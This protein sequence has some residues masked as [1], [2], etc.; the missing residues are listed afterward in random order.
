MTGVHRT[1]LKVCLWVHT[2]A[3]PLLDIH[4]NP[5][6]IVIVKMGSRHL[7]PRMKIQAWIVEENLIGEKLP[8]WKQ[9]VGGD[10]RTL[11]V[12]TVF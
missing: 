10:F 8:R 4:T 1:L 12:Q 6:N 3:W 7:P 2:Y 9:R 5:T 11:F